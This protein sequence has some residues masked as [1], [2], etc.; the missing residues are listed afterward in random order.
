MNE[1]NKMK[2]S[3]RA[4]GCWFVIAQMKKQGESVTLQS[5]ADKTDSSV[6]S[7]RNAVNEL[8]DKGYLERKFIR[9]DGAKIRGISYIVKTSPKVKE[10]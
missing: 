7:V 8:I 2:L 3:L 6:T 10:A 9:E 1:M 5:I 4:L